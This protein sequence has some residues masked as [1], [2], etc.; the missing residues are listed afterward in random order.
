MTWLTV[1][2]ICVT[3]DHGYGQFVVSTAR[4]FTHLWLVTGFVTSV[5]RRVPLVEQ[6]QLRLPEHMSFRVVF[7]LL[8]L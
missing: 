6:E 8:D 3:N 7:V 1:T 4:F 5:T 2:N